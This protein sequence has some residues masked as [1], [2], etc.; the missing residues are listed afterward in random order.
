MATNNN[1]HLLDSSGQVVVDFVW[2]NLPV[3]PNDQRNSANRLDITL[4]NHINTESG[5]SGYPLF[6]PNTTGAD[7]IGYTDYI[8]VPSVLGSTS[9]LAADALADVSLVVTT[10]GGATNTP[11]AVTAASRTV[12]LPTATLTAAGAGAAFP[13]GTSITV[14]AL[15]NTGAELNGVWTVTANATNTVSFV[16]AG[17]TALALSGLAAGTVAGTSGTV[18]TQSVAANAAT[19]VPGTAVTITPFA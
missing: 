2:G 19:I 13:V 15:A 7:V 4:D 11:I 12:N 9:A 16:S 8:L 18:K 17:T 1:G 14:A 6:T 3:Q 5:W 10:A